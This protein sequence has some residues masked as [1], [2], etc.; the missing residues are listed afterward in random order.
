MGSF[1]WGMLTGLIFGLAGASAGAISLYRRMLSSERRARQ[2]ERLAELG[3][4]T[5]GLAHEIKNPLSTVQLNLQLLQE[6]LSPDNPAYSRIVNRLN[7]VHRETSRLRDILDDFWRYAGKLEVERKTVD[8]NQLVEELV[9]FFTPQAQLHKVQ[10]RCKPSTERVEV[11]ADPRLLKQAVLNLMLNAVQ[12]MSD[13]N[14]DRGGEL[15]VSAS[16]HDGEAIIDVIDT[17]GGI[18]PDA[19]A[20]I[21]DPYYS[22][23]KGGTG[24][25][26]AMPRRIGGEHGG[27]VK[28]A[29]HGGK[30]SD[31]QNYLMVEN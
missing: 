10:A 31:S 4:L 16:K 11:S 23:K 19:L 17:A 12:A 15:I 28:E 8:L 14:G 2:A 13:S 20:Q 30:D 5:G 1:G 3:T 18:A 26:L 25:G 9:D 7:L 27:R 21:F 24:L 22:T 29:R 6:D